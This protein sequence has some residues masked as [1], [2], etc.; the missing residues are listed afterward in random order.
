VREFRVDVGVAAI[1][2]LVANGVSA[3]TTTRTTPP[4]IAKPN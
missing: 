4:N 3:A 1:G 2:A